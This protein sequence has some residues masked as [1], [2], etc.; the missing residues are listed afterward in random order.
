M[1]IHPDEAAVSL[2]LEMQKAYA[3]FA[4]A[5]HQHGGDEVPAVSAE[6]SPAVSDS[7][8]TTVDSIPEPELVNAV[9]EVAIAA[10]DAVGAAVTELASVAESYAEAQT[11]P[12]SDTTEFVSR[13]AIA[14][15]GQQPGQENDQSGPAEKEIVAGEVEGT[16]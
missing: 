9:Q 10:A 12:A 11:S 3:A 5:E 1:A 16:R 8:A 15:P 2:E 13:D 7:A 6:V 4:A 14:E